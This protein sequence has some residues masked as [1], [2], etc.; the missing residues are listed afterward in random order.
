MEKEKQFIIEAFNTNLASYI[1]LCVSSRQIILNLPQGPCFIIFYRFKVYCDYLNVGFGTLSRYTNKSTKRNP[2]F[3]LRSAH[4][5]NSLM[6]GYAKKVHHR[7][8]PLVVC[9]VACQV[10]LMTCTPLGK[11]RQSNG[12]SAND[13]FLRY[14]PKSSIVR[15]RLRS[16]RSS[17]LRGYGNRQVEIPRAGDENKSKSYQSQVPI[18]LG[19]DV[20][21]WY[22]R[23]SGSNTCSITARTLQISVNQFS[24]LF[25]A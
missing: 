21:Y 15:C 20:I 14:Q 7:K 23:A 8:S 22:S 2:V 13:A 16:P 3:S 11:Y 25:I 4:P 10:T 12:T 24:S 9:I 19:I 18:Y 5:F 1:D 6:H 17:V